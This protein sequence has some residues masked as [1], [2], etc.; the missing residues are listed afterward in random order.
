MIDFNPIKKDSNKTIKEFPKTKK[1]TF[2]CSENY[3]KIIESQKKL[4]ERSKK[5]ISFSRPIIEREELGVI[6]PNTINVIQG[7]SGVHKSRLVENLCSTLL[8]R[9]EN[10]TFL[11]FKAYDNNCFTVLYVDTER[12]QKDQ[13]PNA[14]QKIKLNAG[15]SIESEIKNFDF[16]S[17]I[18]VSRIERFEALKEYLETV[19]E[20][21]DNHIVIVLDVITDCISNFNDPNETMKLIDLLNMMI[22]EFNVTFICLI[23]ENPS[24]GD[25]AR[26]HLGTEIMNKA[27]TVMQIGFEKD[28]NQKDSEL[29]KVNY[30]KARSTR[31]F[32][33]F[34]LIY[35]EIE[36]G[37]I[38]AEDE[39]VNDYLDAKK[40]KADITQLKEQLSKILIEPKEKSIVI[41]DLVNYF[42]CGTRT[43]ESRLKQLLD[44]TILIKD[45]N[46]VDCYLYKEIK[47]GKTHYKLYPNA[48]E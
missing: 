45:H 38:L 15:Y 13:Y 33:P 35:S 5:Q 22:N 7:K 17:L 28:K 12:N 36:K 4:N 30:L 3:T 31:K 20:K 10:K 29:I 43:I 44:D 8:A 16:I 48:N 32:E 37:L 25:K 14:I 46:G 19:R 41:T 24:S 11:G 9:D 40:S 23:H 34:Y 2:K 6:F 42:K 47:N 1:T 26:G 39:I 21:F 27:S 18:E